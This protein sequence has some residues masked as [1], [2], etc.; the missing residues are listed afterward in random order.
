MRAL[1]SRQPALPSNP[2]LQDS[3]VF[4][5]SSVAAASPCRRQEKVFLSPGLA[6]RHAA[7]SG[8]APELTSSRLLSSGAISWAGGRAARGLRDPGFQPAAFR[9]G[10][11]ELPGGG[12][13]GWVELPVN[14]LTCSSLPAK[15]CST[16][17]NPHPREPPVCFLAEPMHWGIFAQ[18]NFKSVS[19]LPT[20]A[21]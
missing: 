2:R 1:S 5:G 19:S 9:A 7:G 3:R 16:R 4:P 21:V 20:L 8:P 11:R 18:G 12:S 15:C 13:H 6:G 10:C 17:C 14:S